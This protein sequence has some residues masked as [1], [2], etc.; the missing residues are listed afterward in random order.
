M[1]NFWLGVRCRVLCCDST[2]PHEEWAHR[3]TPGGCKALCWLARNAIP[4]VLV[5]NADEAS[6]ET[7]PADTLAANPKRVKTQCTAPRA[8]GSTLTQSRHSVSRLSAA[9][10]QVI[11][12][13]S[14]ASLDAGTDPTAATAFS[15]SNASSAATVPPK[16]TMQCPRDFFIVSGSRAVASR[17]ARDQVCVRAARANAGREPS[18]E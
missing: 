3:L 7:N 11:Q 16:P 15:C 12:P 10:P 8:F 2:G 5:P 4:S 9:Q 14:G 17:T 13:A 1:S 6:A 18:R